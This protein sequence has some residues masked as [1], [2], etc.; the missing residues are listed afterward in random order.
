M[1]LTRDAGTTFAHTNC[2]SVGYAIVRVSPCGEADY[3]CEVR[4]LLTAEPKNLQ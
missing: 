3:S 4:A 1:L 2:G